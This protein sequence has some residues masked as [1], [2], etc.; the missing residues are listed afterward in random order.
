[1]VTKSLPFQAGDPV[2]GA[3]F[4]DREKIIEELKMSMLPLKTGAHQDFALVSPRRFGKSSVLK[5]L[6]ELLRREGIAAI[7]IDCSGTYPRSIEA[8]LE[9]YVEKTFEEFGRVAKWRI[10][11]TRITGAI[12]GTPGAV[13]SVVSSLVSKLGVEVGDF[14]KAWIELRRAPKKDIS[15]LF[16]LAAEL[17]ERLAE[18]TG[19][20]CVAMFDEFQIL[21]EFDGELLWALRAKIQHHKRVGYIISGSSVGIISEMLSDRKSPFFNLFMVRILEPFTDADAQKFLEKRIAGAGMKLSE[22]A[23]KQMLLKTNNIPFNLQWLGLNCYF[24]ARHLRTNTITEEIVELAYAYGLKNIPQFER[25]F[26]RLTERQQ[27]VIHCMAGQGLKRPS[28]IARASGIRDVNV[29]KEL[30]ALVNLGY[31]VKKVRGKYR[32]QDNVFRDWLRLRF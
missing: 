1:M 22:G 21:N 20:P 17:P 30:N 18:K 15:G 26:A 10:L 13:A 4:F 32:F 2:V 14:F 6:Q 7:Y 24:Q 19:I 25:D 12:K 29:I 27:R 28:E 31:L 8:I 11:S 9:G 16:E 3:L 23:L 5:T